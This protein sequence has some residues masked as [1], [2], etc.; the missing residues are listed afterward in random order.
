MVNTNNTNKNEIIKKIRLQTFCVFCLALFMMFVF[1]YPIEKGN[2]ERRRGEAMIYAQ[3][4]GLLIQR[5]LSQ[6]LSAVY[7][8]AAL[9]Q[10]GEGEYYDFDQF[11]E[12]LLPSYEAVSSLQL[13]KNAVVSNIYPLQGNEKAIGHDL[14][15]DKMRV[16]DARKAIETKKLTLSGPYD[17]IQGGISVVGRLPIFQDETAPGDDGRFWGFAVVVVRLDMLLQSTALQRLAEDGYDYEL[18]RLD[19]VSSEWVVFS[20]NSD[21][22]LN[23]TYDFVFDIPNGQWMISMKPR[24]GWVDVHSLMYKS[25]MMLFVSFLIA[26]IAYFIFYR[27]V[28]VQTMVEKRTKALSDANAELKEKQ[29]E[30]H[31]LANYDSLTHLP[32]RALFRQ[33]FLEELESCSQN[34]DSKVIVLLYIDLDQFKAI[35]DT[36][37]H[38]VGDIALQHVADQLKSIVR[39]SD[40]VGRI[41]GDE[42][43]ALLSNLKDKAQGEL[44]AKKLEEAIQ[45][46]FIVDGHELYVTASIGLAAYPEDGFTEEAL[47]KYADMNMYRAKQSTSG[48]G[49][50]G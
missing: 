36:W 17:M 19:S 46:P 7:A 39:E 48:G 16:V 22:R 24:A 40:T 11:A 42:F 13:A 34:S 21:V 8:I 47:M 23:D 35:N 4:Q 41:G 20:S 44:I 6:S 26:A 50:Q 25:A 45:K 1:F 28:A 29:E 3:E 38:D 12:A 27:P 43:I 49:G 37:G 2:I 31:Y 15:R 9:V 14:L 18:S 32:N 10:Q 5:Q 33:K 30:L